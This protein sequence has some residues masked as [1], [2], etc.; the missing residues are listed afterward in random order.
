M[1]VGHIVVVEVLDC[2]GCLD[3]LQMSFK[4]CVTVCINYD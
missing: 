3:E 2:L 1:A 4:F